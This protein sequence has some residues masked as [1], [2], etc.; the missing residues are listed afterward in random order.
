MLQG[1]HLL[2]VCKPDSV[3][4]LMS[5]LNAADYRVKPPK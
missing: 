3:T 2:T 1:G 5:V 4:E